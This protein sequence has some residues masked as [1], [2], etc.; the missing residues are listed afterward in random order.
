[1]K[2]AL[3]TFVAAIAVA[4]A[5]VTSAV[6]RELE[7]EGS[8]DVFIALTDSAPVLESIPESN[9]PSIV[10]E[11]L[12]QHATTSQKEALELLREQS[13]TTSWIA[14]A[15]I[16]KGCPQDLVQKVSA[17]KSVVSVSKLPVVEVP[18]TFMGETSGQKEGT[19]EWGVETVGAPKVWPYYNGKGATVGSID[20]GAYYKHEAIAANFRAEKGWFDAFNKSIASPDD[21]DGH[22]THTIGTMVG[23]NGIGVA[24]GAQWISC[25]GLMNGKGSAETLLACAEFMLCPTD[26]D[27]KNPDCKKAPNVINN[28]W[29]GSSN[30]LWF[31]SAAAAW[32]KAGII[33]VFSNGNSGPAC[34]TVGNPGFLPNVISVGALGSWTTDSPVD[35][36]FFSSKG[37]AVFMGRNGKPYAVVKPD[38]AAPGFFTRSAYI[39]PAQYANMAGTSMAAPHV[40]GVVAL[41]K[42]AKSDLTYKEV[43]QYVTNYAYQKDLTPEPATW[44][45]KANATLPGAPNCG[46]VKDSVWPNNRYGY[47]RIDA[48][49]MFDGG[50]IKPPKPAC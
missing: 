2:A 27:G 39:P 35:L 32:I 18:S 47:G 6:L 33:P 31:K 20:T 24:P 21:I 15:I 29:G 50:D 25:R 42:A 49:N 48:S 7:L 8:S 12:V 38:I 30:D 3:L 45:G 28:S 22:G 46:E 14:N 5:K 11:A 37:P 17:L 43:Y 13:V 40:A 41:L 16:C 44:I 1:M 23:N 19:N 26:V 36:A 4:Q 9:S 10:R 34:A